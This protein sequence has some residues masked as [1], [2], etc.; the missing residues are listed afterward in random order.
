M[1]VLCKEISVTFP[2][3]ATLSGMVSKNEVSNSFGYSSAEETDIE[4]FS[5]WCCFKYQKLEHK[6]HVSTK[7]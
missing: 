1:D 4:I 3:F 5:L 7:A 6:K 2:W